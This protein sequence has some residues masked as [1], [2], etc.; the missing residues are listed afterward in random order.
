M[1]EEGWANAW[2]KGTQ[3][4]AWRSASRSSLSKNRSCD[5]HTE[6]SLLVSGRE[7]AMEFQAQVILVLFLVVLL[8]HHGDAKDT[9]FCAGASG[10]KN[11]PGWHHASSQSSLFRWDNIRSKDSIRFV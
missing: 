1:A 2:T 7:T 8:E 4:A 9:C 10:S 5:L 11:G 3:L 6:V